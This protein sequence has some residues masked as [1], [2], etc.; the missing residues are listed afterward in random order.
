MIF[1]LP[2]LHSLSTLLSVPG[3]AGT[4]EG[5]CRSGE[6]GGSP[7]AVRWAR[8]PASLPDWGGSLLTPQGSQVQ[9]ARCGLPKV[10]ETLNPRSPRFPAVG[11]KGTAMQ[12]AGLGD[13]P[14]LQ[15]IEGQLPARHLLVLL[16]RVRQAHR[17]PPRTSGV[18]CPQSHLKE[19]CPTVYPRKGALDCRSQWAMHSVHLRQNPTVSHGRWEDVS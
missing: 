1:L 4:E 11:C 7:G 8:S 13:A 9:T 14:H 15:N 2:P 10:K 17:H 6:A 18:R 3:G 5:R 12:F 19:A 16:G